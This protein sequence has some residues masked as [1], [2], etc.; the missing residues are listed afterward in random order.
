MKK[1]MTI[2]MLATLWA[3]FNMG[4]NL[5]NANER[6]EA[7]VGHVI[8]SKVNGTNVDVSKLF[9]HEME[10]IAHEFALNSISIMQQY[11]PY[12]LEQVMADMR[13]KADTKYKCKLLEGGTYECKQ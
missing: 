8:Q 3:F 9:E 4:L 6:T 5:A 7:T 13:M 1:L 11:L 2:L 12:L 10:K